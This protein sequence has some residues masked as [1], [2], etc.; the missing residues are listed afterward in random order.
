[1]DRVDT[2]ATVW[3]GLTAG[4]A[5]C[6]DHKY[7]P[8]SQKEFYRLFAYFNNVPERGKAIK[9]GNSPPMILA[10]TRAQQAELARIQADLAAAETAFATLGPRI[11]SLQA[12]W[13]RSPEAGRPIPWSLTCGLVASLSL[14]G[15]TADRCRPTGAGCFRDG[16]PSYTAGPRALAGDFDGRRFVDAGDAAD[17]GF[18]DKFSCGAWVRPADGQGG[19]ILSRMVDEDRGEGYSLSLEGGKVHV[20][21]VKRWLDDAIR[22][23]T[24]R[25]VEPGCWHHVLMTYDGSR[26]AAGIKVYLD[27]RP[28]RLKVNLDD[29]NQSFKTAEPLRIGAGGGPHRRFRGAIADVRVYNEALSPA[30]AALVATP[31]TVN[32]I[33]ALPAE[34]RSAGQ[35]W[36]LRSY[37][38]AEQAPADVRQ[39]HRRLLALRKQGQQFLEAIPTT[40]VMAEMKAPRDTFVLIRGEYDK[41]GAKVLPGVPA[42]LP[43]LP[44]GA[45]NNR[46]GLARWLV[47]RSNP[48]T[49]RVAVNRYW[50][51][52]FGTGLVKTVEDLGSQGEWP[53]HAELLDWLATEFAGGGWDV[54]ALQR[55]IVTSATYRQSSRAGKALLERDPEN[56]L[57]ARGPRF[58]LPA[59]MIRDQA[60]AVSGLLVER[61]GGPSVKPYQPQGLWEELSG[62]KYVQDHGDKLYRRSLYTFWKRTAAPPAMVTFDAAGRETCVVRETRTN[63]PLQALNLMNDVTYAEAARK[64]AERV[65]KEGGPTPAARLTLAFRLAAARRPRPTE[66]KVLC[67][68]LERHLSHYRQDWAAAL[69][70]VSAGES[71]RDE[72]LDVSELAAYTAIAGLLLNLDEII[73]RE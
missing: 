48:L 26:L 58:R 35:A 70:L 18:F 23:E 14:D 57:L 6:H 29:I 67:A 11:A 4:C 30:D 39:A 72:R 41:K 28:Q 68:G 13:E 32:E 59:G 53:S 61:L 65:L 24:E 3:L 7:D 63:T 56:R 62:D 5:R 40:M 69:H 20:H 33:A 31:E 12:A 19:T 73:T 71:R 10:P 37:Y 9:Y 66:L 2:T 16:T 50:Q 54:K 52:Y 46:L 21:L 51:M 49:A 44:A 34:R 15:Q 42:S 55:R 1:V 47:D 36:K 64:L 22:V 27:G 43:P 25:S 45:P 60:L 8:I 17:F 38:L